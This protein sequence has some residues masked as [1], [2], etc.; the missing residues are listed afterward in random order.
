MDQSGASLKTYTRRCQW[1]IALI[2]FFFFLL[3]FILPIMRML[4]EAGNSSFKEVR[5]LVTKTTFWNIAWF[6]FWQAC[7]STFLSI[8][9]SFPTVYLLAKYDFRGRKLLRTLLTVPFILP[10]VVVG[11]AFNA[12]FTR[13]NLNDG[14]FQLRHTIWAIF[15]AHIFFN[16]SIA[17]RVISTYWENLDSR[18]EEQARLLGGNKRKVFFQITLPRLMPAVRSSASL[19][20]L[21]CITSFAVILMLGGPGKATIETEIWRQAIWRGDFTS[22]SALA[23]IQIFFVV[24][25]SL[26]F[27][28]DGKKSQI[29]DYLS[30]RR[31]QKLSYRS[32]IFHFFYISVLFGLPITF[33][34]ERSIR[35]S[36]GYSLQFFKALGEKTNILPVSP[37]SSLFNSLQF[38]FIASF[39]AVFIGILAS[40]LI[41][42]GGRLFSTFINTTLT[43][44]IGVSA[45]TLGFG[46]LLFYTG[47]LAN[48][49]DSRWIVPA[50]HAVLGI[51]FVI[52]NL[53]PS[54]MR[55]PQKFYDNALLLGTS[56]IKIWKDID[57]KLSWRPLLVGAGF[58]FAISLGEFGATSFI[59][60]QADRLT[61]PLVIF[62]LLGT[63][64]DSL[65]GQAMA[66]SVLLLLITAIVIL[67]IERIRP[68]EDFEF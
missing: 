30:T 42:H 10:T 61:A 57:L 41:V 49:R 33:L 12:M 14:S 56:P 67:L 16:S 39:L 34:I 4:Q 1:I 48:L 20:F 2:P 55:I 26:L 66:L 46:I 54:M 9:V 38:A 51:P 50:L 27:N 11:S 24:I 6:T 40:T 63:P 59:P 52:R 21:F 7:V 43:L 23:F 64:G 3:F 36:N 8:A 68:S 28:H 19:I 31:T 37:I 32:S 62:R 15:L 13:L 35:N 65:R 44:P 45:V 53:V 47:P 22:A 25:I 17:I 18:P 5:E 60:R 29:H 58:S